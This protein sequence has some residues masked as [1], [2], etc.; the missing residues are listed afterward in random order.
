MLE[1][2]KMA[3]AAHLHVLLRRKVGRVIDVEWVMRSP[4]YAREIIRV[5]REQPRDTH[6]DLH[7]W[8]DKLELALTGRPAAAPAPATT[9]RPAAAPAASPANS[10]FGRYVGRLR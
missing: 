8:A 5:S 9:P 1:S 2:E 7:E 6:A 10:G 3:I 4:E